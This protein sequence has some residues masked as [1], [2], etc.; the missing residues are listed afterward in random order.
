MDDL[1]ILEEKP[2]KFDVVLNAN[3]ESQERNFLKLKLSF[4]IPES[5]PFTTPL[6]RLKNLTP[7]IIDNNRMIEFERLI[8]EKADESIG[9]QMIYD[10][11]E[12]LRE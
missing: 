3:N 8:A 11:C 9:N 1:V 7:D 10:I 4:E 2:Y 12:G 5:Y 6:V